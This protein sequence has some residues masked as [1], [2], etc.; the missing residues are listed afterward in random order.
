MNLQQLQYFLTTAERGSFSA[1]AHALHLSQPSVSEQVRRLEAELGVALFARVGRGLV[2]TDAGRTLRPHAE[3]VLQEVQEA[4]ESV[5]AVRELR[6]G[7]VS[8]GTFSTARD[9]MGSDLVAEFRRRHPNVRVRI[10]G[11]NS[12]EAAQDVRDGRLEA[13]IVALPVD[14]EGLDVRRVTDDELFFASTE[15]SHLRTPMTI[16]RMAELPLVM[17]DASYRLQDP[18]R[19][20]LAELAQRAGVTLD[21]VVEVETV[22]TVLDLVAAGAGD[23]VLERGLLVS[24]GGR[25]SKRIGWV[26]FAD[27]III[28]LAWVTRRDAPL[29]PAARV[30]VDLIEERLHRTTAE[31]AGTP[32]RRL[33]S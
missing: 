9:Y 25:M 31:L 22:A 23:T 29:S 20:Q 33:P 8:I 17:G 18:T 21:P 12:A 5:V 30:M 15:A 28:T 19:R 6:G 16:E 32:R 26:P 24:R 13:A 11:V 27:P 7:T 1:A 14:D 4:R 2:L 10:L 3:A